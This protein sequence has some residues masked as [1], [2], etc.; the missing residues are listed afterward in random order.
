MKKN[1]ILALLIILVQSCQVSKPITVNEIKKGRT[2][3][4]THS[5]GQTVK[6]KCK[7]VNATSISIKINGNIMELPKSQIDSVKRYKV[8]TIKLLG[9]LTLAGIG[10]AILISNA[11]KGYDK[12][13]TN[14]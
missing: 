1:I 13:K 9:G 8:S 5:N 10:A 2:Y 6:V 7:D 12:P 4:I 14:Y 11:E 3:E